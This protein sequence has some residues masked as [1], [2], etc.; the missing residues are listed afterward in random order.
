MEEEE[1]E[2][3]EGGRDGKIGRKDKACQQSGPPKR[4]PNM[5]PRHIAFICFFLNVLG[6]KKD[7]Q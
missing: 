5:F 2:E 7:P 4:K 3:E 1:E 6:P